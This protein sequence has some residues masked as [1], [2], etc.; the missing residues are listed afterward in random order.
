MGGRGGS[1]LVPLTVSLLYSGYSIVW[2]YS[3]VEG[4]LDSMLLVKRLRCDFT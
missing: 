1:L 4:L 2:S 3:S